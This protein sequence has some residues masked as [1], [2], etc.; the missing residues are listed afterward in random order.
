MTLAAARGG[1]T[2]QHAAHRS[3]KGEAV[4]H[5]HHMIQPSAL[6][7]DRCSLSD[8]YWTWRFDMRIS[9]AVIGCNAPRRRLT[10]AEPAERSSVARCARVVFDSLA[11]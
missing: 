7:R 2:T 11:G 5:L 6:S 4:R 8:T 10:N 1:V 9:P 3:I